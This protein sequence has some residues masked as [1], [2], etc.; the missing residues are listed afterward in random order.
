VKF[1]VGILNIYGW[2]VAIA[3]VLGLVVV[4]AIW[5]VSLARGGPRSKPE[6]RSSRRH[7]PKL[8]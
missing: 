8:P 6:R 5:L 3:L 4:L 1:L 7:G 2:Y